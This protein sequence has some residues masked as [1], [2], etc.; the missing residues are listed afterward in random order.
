MNTIIELQTY[1]TTL[2]LFKTEFT[3]LLI[4]KMSQMVQKSTKISSLVCAIFIL[5]KKVLHLIYT[6]VYT[7]HCSYLD[8][9][10]SRKIRLCIVDLEGKFQT[11]QLA[12]PII[13]LVLKFKSITPLLFTNCCRYSKELTCLNYDLMQ[14]SQFKHFHFL[15]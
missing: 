6:L 4:S 13:F 8:I 1:F 15:E 10:I 9:Y 11:N 3:C 5:W 14:K 7:V 2:Y 12:E